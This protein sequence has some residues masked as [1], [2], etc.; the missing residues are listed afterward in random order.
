LFADPCVDVTLEADYP[1]CEALFEFDI[2][3]E[4][5]CTPAGDLTYAWVI[6]VQGGANLT[7]TGNFINET[8]PGGVH[9]VTVT[10]Y[11]LCGN[12]DVCIFDVT[13][14]GNN[15]PSPICLASVVWVLDDEG[16]ADV[17]A[18]DFDLKSEGGCGSTEDLV[19]SFTHPDVAI[20][21]NMSFDCSD[22]ENGIG[23]NIPLEVFVIDASGAYE[24]CVVTLILQ[25]SQGVCEDEDGARAYLGGKVF[26]ESL[27][28]IEQVEVQLYENM[29]DLMNT[30]MTSAGDYMFQD[31]PFYNGYMV[32]PSK[33]DHPL[34]GV[35]TLDIVLIQKH[36][37]GIQDLNSPYKLI[38]ADVNKS[39]SIS[40]TDLIEIRK[41]I[42]GLQTEW[43]NV[44]PWV[45]VPD[46]HIFADDE[47]P[48]SFPETSV[49]NGLYVSDA[50]VN[51]FGIKMGDVTESAIVNFSQD[52]VESRSS[53][54][55][56]MET[57]NFEFA[58]GG[59][60]RIPF[61]A[62]NENS[63]DGLQFTVE[64]DASV[65]TY[66][67]YEGGIFG[68]KDG[69]IGTQRAADGIITISYD[70]IT[71]IDINVGDALFTLNFASKT[72]AEV[73]DVISI[74]SAVTTA[75]AYDRNGSIQDITLLSS[76]SV[77]EGESM[78]LFQNQPNP[79]NNS[80]EI[81]FYLPEAGQATLKVMSADGKVIYTD[82]GNYE[83]GMNRVN[84]D[85]SNLGNKGV[86][87]YRLEYFLRSRFL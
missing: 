12:T 28:D 15:P 37:L 50:D 25:D 62:V 39:E 16:Q 75:Q 63:I 49:Y 55:L 78:E 33:D 5:N 32:K 60:L 79:F 73:E 24:S 71:G 53:K 82:V 48:W 51:F 41:V 43:N 74:N 45:F 57:S 65:L 31:I 30:E 3:A 69:N 80:T 34:N 54:A 70:D 7:G 47:N 77:T 4:D 8:L 17:W 19:F 13:V 44:E 20:T 64:F 10:T 18:S 35:S 14:I 26:T 76:E 67:G 36:I 11:D 2:W 42:L 9:Q 56:R 81:G 59:E 46:N 22:L 85:A 1:N 84:L 29:I 23:E 83:K 86:L 61:R 58:A 52:A 87:L 72:T 40:A 68:L 6:Q 21:P 38:A 66:N 27:V